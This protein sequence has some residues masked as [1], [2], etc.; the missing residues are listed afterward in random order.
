[1]EMAPFDNN[2][3]QE[4]KQDLLLHYWILGQDIWKVYRVQIAQS[5]GVDD[6]REK[7]KHSNKLALTGVDPDA[8]DLWK[9][10]IMIA[11]HI[12]AV[13]AGDVPV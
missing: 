7:I 2:P 12:C 13:N 1:M 9:V 5:E 8:L 3:Q 4:Q 11:H 6:L 10:S